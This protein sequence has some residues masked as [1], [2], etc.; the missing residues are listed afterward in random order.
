MDGTLAHSVDFMVTI[1]LIMVFASFV[2]FFFIAATL[3]SRIPREQRD[4]K[5]QK[6]RIA[7]SFFLTGLV[8]GAT[9]LVSESFF[10][11]LLGDTRPSLGTLALLSVATAIIS[12]GASAL[13]WLLGRNLE[14]KLW[15]GNGYPTISK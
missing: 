4:R 5:P 14:G 10:L 7:F 13:G 11:L 8:S 1:M 15:P 9:L 2:S 3:R 12:S 6:S